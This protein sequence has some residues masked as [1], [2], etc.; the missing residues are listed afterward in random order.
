MSE[1][2]E[3]GPLMSLFGSQRSE[4]EKKIDLSLK[5]LSGL[6]NQLYLLRGAGSLH[7]VEAP[8]RVTDA[9]EWVCNQLD[10]AGLSEAKKVFHADESVRLGPV[11]EMRH[12]VPARKGLVRLLV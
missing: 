5:T 7:L 9:N 4:L 12:Q 2:A 11:A 8:A 1:P 3:F 10:K 6:Q